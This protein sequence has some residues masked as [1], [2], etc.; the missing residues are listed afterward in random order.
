MGVSIA[1]D[2]CDPVKAFPVEDRLVYQPP[3][4][5]AV[6]LDFVC[7]DD[8]VH[9]REVYTHSAAIDA[10][11]LKQYGFVIRIKCVPKGLSQRRSDMCVT[12]MGSHA[13]LVKHRV[14]P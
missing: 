1:N 9:N 11:F 6:G 13:R 12:E 3:E 5:V 4:A 14:P 2:D 7:M 10:Q 8:P